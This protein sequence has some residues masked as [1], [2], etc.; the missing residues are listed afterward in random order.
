MVPEMR[1]KIGVAPF[2]LPVNAS[3][4]VPLPT[5]FEVKSYQGEL[6]IGA[7]PWHLITKTSASKLEVIKSLLIVKFSFNKFFAIT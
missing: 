1:S 2:D 7:N 6:V 3:L 5:L 4:N